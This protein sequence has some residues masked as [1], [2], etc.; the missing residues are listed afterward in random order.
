MK[1]QCPRCGSENVEE[2]GRPDDKI[3]FECLGEC[4][5]EI[6]SSLSKHD[7]TYFQ[8]DIR[9]KTYCWPANCM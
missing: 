7:R 8:Y 4:S 6:L 5:E 2:L 9:D 1:V 3:S